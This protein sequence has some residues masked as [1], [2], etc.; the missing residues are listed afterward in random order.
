LVSYLAFDPASRRGVLIDAV[1]DYDHK[2]GYSSTGFADKMIEAARQRG[3][4]RQ[5]AQDRRCDAGG[6]GP[7]S[8]RPAKQY[9]GRAIAA[10]RIQWNHLSEN[11]VGR[12]QAVFAP[13]RPAPWNRKSLAIADRDRVITDHGYASIYPSC[14]PHP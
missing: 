9:S 13:G 11:P 6:T 4:I 5:A 12:L 8:I 3:G 2:A 7:D 1:R 10:A 14:L